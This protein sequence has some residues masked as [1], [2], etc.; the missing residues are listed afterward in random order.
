[1]P[2]GNP[3]PK[4]PDGMTVFDNGN[5]W[6][7]CCNHEV[8]DFGLV[9]NRV[10]GTRPYDGQASGGVTAMVINK[11]T[12]L[13]VDHYVLLSGTLMNCAGG[14][15][16]WK[17]WITCEELTSGPA[18]GYE[19]HHGY[20]FEVS[21]NVPNAAPVPLRQMGRFKHE[22]IAVDRRGGVIYLTE[23][24]NPTSG[25]YRYTPHNYGKPAFGGRLQMLAI[26]GTPNAD[27]RTGQTVN[28]PLLAAWVDIVDPDPPNGEANT[29]AVYD[30]GF[31]LGGATF[32][33]L[34]GCFT[35]ADRIFFTSTNGGN[36]GLGQIWEYRQRKGNFGILKLIYESPGGDILDFPDNICFGNRGDTFICEDGLTDNYMRILD[37]RG[38]L[39]T[40]AKNIIPGFESSEIT[41]SVLSP[42]GQVLFFNIQ[43]PGVTVA[44]WGPW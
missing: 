20:C 8:F 7:L 19:K 25:F 22:A 33:R 29:L 4:R 41:G 36:S 43:T 15:T 27:L 30:Q 6:T 5:T 18:S 21:P 3:T 24:F 44:V 31:A 28:Q 35:F 2:N 9:E 40:F 42:N 23:D 16:P 39:T 1:M 10:I 34:K 14:I 26:K 13:P 17:T 32:T 37:K 12:K 11:H 38:A